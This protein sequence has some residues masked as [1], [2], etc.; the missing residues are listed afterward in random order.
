MT[1]C[2]HMCPHARLHIAQ[3]GRTPATRTQTRA[4]LDLR[5]YVHVEKHAHTGTHSRTVARDTQGWTLRS[6][7]RV[8][9]CPF[10]RGVFQGGNVVISLGIPLTDSFASSPP[11]FFSCALKYANNACQSLFLPSP[12][13]SLSRLSCSSSA[14]LPRNPISITANKSNARI[15]RAY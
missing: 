11:P 7:R 2:M 15:K 13:H 9:P 14:T 4:C 8:Y 3:A 1:R 10:P 5:V 6:D 12:F